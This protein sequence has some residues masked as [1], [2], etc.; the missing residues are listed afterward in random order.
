MLRATLL[1][2][3]A[4]ALGAPATAHAADPLFTVAGGGVAQPRNDL[5]AGLAQLEE[6]PPVAA[7]PDGQF[8]IG[9]SEQVWRVDAQGTMH[10]VAGTDRSG[11]TGDGGP[12]SLA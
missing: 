8:L 12:A 11:Y 5:P 1:V 9:T 10:L 2:A 6:G 4:L 7:L 3:A